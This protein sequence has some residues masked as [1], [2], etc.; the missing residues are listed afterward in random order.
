M[1]QRDFGLLLGVSWFVYTE[2][3][4]QRLA[5][6]GFRDIRPPD[7]ELFRLLH[8]REGMTITEIGGALQITKQGASKIV[9]GLEK[10]GYV[11]REQ[12]AGDHRERWVRLSER[13]NQVREL[14]VRLADEIEQEIE[15]MA[16]RAAVEGLRQALT[17]F[18]ETTAVNG[19]PFTRLAASIDQQSYGS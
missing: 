9:I 6:A 16:G 2:V 15:V 13:G 12:V 10:R 17:T 19:S 7:G 8:H 4:R 3:L 11:Y 18:I 1:A 14:A 5:A